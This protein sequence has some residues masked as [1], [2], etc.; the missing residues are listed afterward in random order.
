MRQNPVS[1]VPFWFIALIAA[2]WSITSHALVVSI[3]EFTI[4]RNGAMFFTDSFTDG[5]EPPSA[6]NFAGGGAASYAVFGTIP[7]TAEAGGR[8]LLDTASG[9]L[10]FNALGQA[11]LNVIAT[12]LTNTS[13]APADLGLGL[14]SD[15]TL[16]VTGIFSL[17]TPPG[18]LFSG[19]GLFLTDSV[20]PGTTHQL[21]Q[22]IV[23]F[24][25]AT[26][27]PLILYLLQDFDAHTIAVLGAALL[28]P[29]AGADEILLNLSR[30]DTANDNFFG[31]FAYLTGGVAGPSTQ[32]L[33]PG[34]GFQGEE[35]VRAQFFIA[36]AVP[37]PATLALLGL[38]LAGLGFSRRRKS[39]Q[40]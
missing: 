24:N 21:L 16:S 19:Y 26:G 13:N 17:T 6:P 34:Q 37:E 29:P 18:P 36:Q 1:R 32:F 7:S 11:R 22:I 15:D 9:A 28:A 8:L 30:P 3:D 33:L 10:T 27:Q 38:G 5:N 39:V 31:S 23:D 2:G 25:V 14:K 12:L 40:A 20:G 4:T 35:F